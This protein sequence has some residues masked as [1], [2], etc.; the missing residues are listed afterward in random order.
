MTS[1]F[2]Y[3]DVKQHNGPTARLIHDALGLGFWYLSKQK[4]HGHWSNKALCSSQNMSDYWSPS[5]LVCKD[6][7]SS[8]APQ[9]ACPAGDARPEPPH[10]GGEK[11]HPRCHGPAEERRGKGAVHAEVSALWVVYKMQIEGVG[12]WGETWMAWIGCVDWFLAYG[13]RSKTWGFN[14]EY[15][16]V[17]NGEITF[18]LFSQMLFHIETRPFVPFWLGIVLATDAIFAFIIMH[19]S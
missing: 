4:A 16:M 13:G 3:I 8:R 9:R 11:D 2:S 12:Y 14:D 10:R 6:V 15:L 19:T 18:V 7:C 1:Y 5:A 17:R